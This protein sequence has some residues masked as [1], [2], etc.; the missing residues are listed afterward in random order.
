MNGCQNRISVSKTIR[1]L[2]FLPVLGF[3]F[4]RKI[5]HW[6]STGMWIA[7]PHKNNPVS[8]TQVT[9]TSAPW[10]SLY[11]WFTFGNGVSSYIDYQNVFADFT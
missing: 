10:S 7:F 9:V 4:S 5:V 8:S 6:P 2:C 1:L 11:R 3:E